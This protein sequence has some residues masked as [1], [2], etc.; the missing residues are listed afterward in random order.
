[1][2]RISMIVAADA[3]NGIGIDNRLPWKLAEDM[4]FFKQT[5]SGHAVLMGRKTFESIGRPLPQRRN[6]V[7][8]RDSGWQA[9]GV[10]AHT[11]LEQAIAAAQAAG[12]TELFIIGGSQIYA[13][14]MPHAERIL[15]TRI[16]RRF[17][18][19]AHFPALPDDV[20]Q[21]TAQQDGWSEQNGCAYHFLCYQR[22]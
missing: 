7:L 18:C 22:R 11:S 9:A 1:M 16:E 3:A 21:L 2:M 12:E 19:D 8:S 14:A 5:T 10:S 20:W 13:A 4:A 17:D 6:L 15:L